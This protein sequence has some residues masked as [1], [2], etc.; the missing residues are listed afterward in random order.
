MCSVGEMDKT[1]TGT[2]MYMTLYP[3][4]STDG[5]LRGGNI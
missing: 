5:G 4:K 2:K 1:E 3:E